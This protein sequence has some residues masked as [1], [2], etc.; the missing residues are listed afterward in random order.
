MKYLRSHPNK[1]FINRIYSWDNSDDNSMVEGN[2]SGKSIIFHRQV[3]KLETDSRDPGCTFIDQSLVVTASALHHQSGCQGM[4]K[5]SESWRPTQRSCFRKKW[6]T[7]H[8]L[9][10]I[11]HIIT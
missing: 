6:Y 11:Y 5:H 4:K 9:E 3:Y 10:Y 8:H 7:I 1:F 2:Y